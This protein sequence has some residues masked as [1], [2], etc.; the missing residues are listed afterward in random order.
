MV[1]LIDAHASGLSGPYCSTDLDGRILRLVLPKLK[2]P[3][4]CQTI[5]LLLSYGSIL[6]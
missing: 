2:N 6:G 4:T 1:Q 5:L 3:N